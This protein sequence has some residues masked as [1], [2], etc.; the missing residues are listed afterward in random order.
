MIKIFNS[1]V[2]EIKDLTSDVKL[3]RISVP[4]DFDFK[5]GQYLSLSVI[6]RDGKKIRKPF[7]IS[8]SPLN[9]NKYVEFCIKIIQD[10]L[11]SEFLKTLK[12]GDRL[13]LFGPLGKFFVPSLDRNLIFIASGVGIA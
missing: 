3:F 1:K 6:R 9:K 5:A 13:E 2:L 8:N 4:N 10:G 7:S 11:A 12:K